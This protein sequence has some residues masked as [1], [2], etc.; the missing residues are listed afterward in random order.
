MYGSVVRE[1]KTIRN[2]D[3]HRRLRDRVLPDLAYLDEDTRA[4]EKRLEHVDRLLLVLADASIGTV[5]IGRLKI[6]AG[7]ESSSS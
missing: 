1:R 2:F 4:S 3:F 5:L 7:H 6:A